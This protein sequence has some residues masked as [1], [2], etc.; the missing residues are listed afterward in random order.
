MSATIIEI[1]RPPRLD[2]R[3]EALAALRMELAALDRVREY[4]TVESAVLRQTI[5]DLGRS[6]IDEAAKP[7]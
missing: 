5:R 2:E 3:E 1:K 7:R 4:V 6:A